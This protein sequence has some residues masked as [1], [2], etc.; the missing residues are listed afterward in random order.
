MKKLT[1]TIMTFILL[2][3]YSCDSS[4]EMERINSIKYN[5]EEHLIEIVLL[6]Y[7]QNNQDGYHLLHLVFLGNGFDELEMETNSENP[8]KLSNGS[9]VIV[10]DPTGQNNLYNANLGNIDFVNGNIKVKNLNEP[11]NYEIILEFEDQSGNSLTGYYK[12]FVQ[13]NN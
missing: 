9:Y 11:D 12:G 4:D 2:S 5:G 13:Y 10:D 1:L 3:L 7:I 6:E 8:D